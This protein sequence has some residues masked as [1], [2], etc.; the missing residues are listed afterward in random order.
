MTDFQKMHTL[1]GSIIKEV[2]VNKCQ[3]GDEIRALLI[4]S[5][6]AHYNNLGHLGESDRPNEE[7]V[8]AYSDVDLLHTYSES[9]ECWMD[10][11]ENKFKAID[12]EIWDKL[13]TKFY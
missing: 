7:Q 12:I 6:L 1:V 9:C 8:A 5:E 4:K 10:F 11:E 13:V 2:E 3:L